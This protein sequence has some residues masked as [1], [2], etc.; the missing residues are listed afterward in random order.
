MVNRRNNRRKRPNQQRRY[1]RKTGRTEPF[2]GKMKPS[3][4]PK[5]KNT[6]EE[7]KP[8]KPVGFRP[9][10]VAS[11]PRT[12][13]CTCEGSVL[14]TTN[15]RMLGKLREMRPRAYNTTTTSFD[16]M[17]INGAFRKEFRHHMPHFRTFLRV[18]E[19]RFVEVDSF[20]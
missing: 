5:K 14:E 7:P 11:K 6:E 18:S 12:V 17:V 16:V 20:D 1:N 19:I 13:P 2:L 8:H 3:K 4:K 10:K 9:I 15:Q